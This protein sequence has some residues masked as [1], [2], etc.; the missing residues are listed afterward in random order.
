MGEENALKLKYSKT[1]SDIINNK[2][3]L[4]AISIIFIIIALFVLKN[5]KK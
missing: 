2:L 3:V 1:Q 4:G 5:K